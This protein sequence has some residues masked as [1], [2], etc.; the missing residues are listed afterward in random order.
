MKLPKSFSLITVLI[1]LLGYTDLAKAF[2]NPETGSFLNRDPIEERGGEN[3]YG[4]VKNDGVN[5]WD[6][7]GMATINAKSSDNIDSTLTDF[8]DGGVSNNWIF[9]RNHA[10]AKRFETHQAIMPLMDAYKALT[11]RLCES[12]EPMVASGYLEQNFSYQFT[13]TFDD[14]VHDVIT[15]LGFYGEGTAH[16][17]HGTNAFGSFHLSGY[18]KLDCCSQK[19]WISIT[20]MNTWSMSSLLRNPIT[21]KPLSSSSA[22][23]PVSVQVEIYKLEDLY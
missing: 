13:A 20:I 4:F 16:K 10:L 7:L 22:L 9:D 5:A 18:A 21:R 15:G 2:Y 1:I 8:F 17:D 11:K 12:G 23:N 3:L 6:Y 14:F 19:K